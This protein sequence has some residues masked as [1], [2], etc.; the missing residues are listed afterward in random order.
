[1]L[2][3]RRNLDKSL[4]EKTVVEETAKRIEMYVQKRVRTE[5]E[6][7]VF[8]VALQKKI[9]DAKQALTEKMLGPCPTC[10]R[11]RECVCE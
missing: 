8:L 4:E 2:L 1:M 6:S 11:E 3:F 9:D 10:H 7:D 5:L